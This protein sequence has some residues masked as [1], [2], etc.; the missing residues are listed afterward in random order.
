M[1]INDLDILLEADANPDIKAKLRSALQQAKT[2]DT[3]STAGKVRS[4]MRT[5]A[6]PENRATVGDKSIEKIDK[7]V[8][9]KK[10]F[11]P[12]LDKAVATGDVKRLSRMFY[13]AVEK[14]ADVYISKFPDY[15]VLKQKSERIIVVEKLQRSGNVYLTVKYIPKKYQKVI[16]QKSR[17][18]H[19]Q[20]LEDILEWA[21]R[22]Q[23][24]EKLKKRATDEED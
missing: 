2:Q 18:G 24:I 8:N 1:K 7:I 4:T 20:F 14:I 16:L 10:I 23:D 11:F 19:E 12:M 9:L 21:K 5:L 13:N 3:S 22:Q 17:F 6:Q 15:S